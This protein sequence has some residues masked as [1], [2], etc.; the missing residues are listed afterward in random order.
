M[1]LT[2][3]QRS[4]VEKTRS[5]G[6]AKEAEPLSDG[7]CLYLVGTIAR[8]LVLLPNFLN[9]KDRRSLSFS[10]SISSNVRLSLGIFGKN[11]KRSWVLI[12]MPTRSFLV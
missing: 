12:K 7:D 10:R 3:S 6:T 1:A 8:D 4:L 2:Q 5:V 11:L 9:C